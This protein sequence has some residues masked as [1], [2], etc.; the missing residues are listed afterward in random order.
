[1]EMEAFV[2]VDEVPVEILGF[3]GLHERYIVLAEKFVRIN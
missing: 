1:M 3:L 2:V